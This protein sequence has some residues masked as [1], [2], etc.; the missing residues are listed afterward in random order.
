MKHVLLSVVVPTYNRCAL[1]ARTLPALLTH[2][3]RAGGTEVIVVVDGSKDQTVEMLRGHRE[4]RRLRIV[5]QENRGLAAARN[6]GAGVASSEV[7]LFLDDDMILRK[8]ALEAHLAAHAD[9]KERVAFGALNL[10]EGP[11][12]SFLKMGVEIWGKEMAERLS[13]PGHRFRF[14]D[15]HFGHASISLPL[16]R[17]AGGFDESFVRFGNEDYDL[18][19][20]LIQMGAEMRF[21]AGA[22][23]CQTY[24]K[25]LYR[26]LRD[27]ACVGMADRALAQKHPTLAGEL[28]FANL[29]PHPLRR[30]AR[31]S[32]LAAVD[33]LGP[34]WGVMEAALA[35][36][37]ML[38]ARGSLLGKAQT[39]LGERRYWKGIRL[40][41]TPAR[42]PLTAGEPERGRVA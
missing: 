15:C 12:R 3:H 21:L 27:C 29:P 19:F 42:P 41:G 5:V 23:A 2:A 25:G 40:A 31:L 22:S 20:R 34:A 35:S 36:L 32:G 26:W 4:E 18:G 9:R 1:L 14:D 8:G 11:R 7:V 16:F 39:L 24:D 17:R 38:G 37:E 33:P 10:A 28:R 13:S 30:L 6:R